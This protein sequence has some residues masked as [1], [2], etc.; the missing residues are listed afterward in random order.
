MK[1]NHVIQLNVRSKLTLIQNQ[2]FQ[3][4]IIRSDFAIV[5]LLLKFGIYPRRNERN[6]QGLTG[7]QQCVLDGNGRLAILLLEAGADIEAKTSNG[8]TCLHIAAALG[9]LDIVTTLVNHCSDMIALTKNEELPIDLAATREIK[10]KLAKEMSRIGYSELAQWY[11]RKLAAREGVFYVLS[12]DTLLDLACDD[13]KSYAT[14]YQYFVRPD[15]VEQNDVY[16]QPGNQQSMTSYWQVH[17]EEDGVFDGSKKDVWFEYPNNENNTYLSCSSGYLSE[18]VFDKSLGEYKKVRNS[19]SVSSAGSPQRRLPET[20]CELRNAKSMLS[21]TEDKKVEDFQTRCS[22]LKRSTSNRRRDSMQS[23]QRKPSKIELHIDYAHTADDEQEEDEGE[24]NGGL[25]QASEIQNENTIICNT[26]ENENVFENHKEKEQPK[27]R[28]VEQVQNKSNVIEHVQ[29]NR[30]V[31]EHVQSNRQVVEHGKNSEQY[32]T[33]LNSQISGTTTDLNS[34]GTTT[35][36]SGVTTDLNL[37]SRNRNVRFS[38]I[39]NANEF[40]NC[41]NCKK[42]GYAFS[43][44]IRSPNRKVIHIGEPV[45]V[46]RDMQP[47]YQIKKTY[48][49][50]HAADYANPHYFPATTDKL[51]T[52]YGQEYP[53]MG[54]HATCCG[55]EYKPR[56]KKKKLFSGIKSMFKDSIKVHRTNSDQT[57]MI[58]DAGILFAVSLRDRGKSKTIKERQLV[59]KSNSFSGRRSDDF[60]KEDVYPHDQ[61]VPP[62]FHFSDSYKDNGK[63]FYL[64]DDTFNSSTNTITQDTVNLPN[65]LPYQNELH[66]SQ[67]NSRGYC[68]RVNN[69]YNTG[70]DSAE[71]HD[72]KENEVFYDDFYPHQV[73][74]NHC[75]IETQCVLSDAR[76]NTVM[77][78][79]DVCDKQGEDCDFSATHTNKV[80]N[81]STDVL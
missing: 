33:Q 23:I 55:Q 79:M 64:F 51:S 18:V 41:P 74:D 2:I 45:Y 9:D 15:S 26:S 17:D 49:I 8:W 25:I 73:A 6:I 72:K 47:A 4:A 42:M 62:P 77:S 65:E 35:D 34:K 68:E 46:S 5:K 13:N 78:H 60:L 30:H 67:N 37:D 61:V 53:T 32:Y 10:I 16:L 39:D 48:G 70:Y 14:G 58:D 57:P 1:W 52:Y 63:T 21:I 19:S 80:E 38:K 81:G 3:E 40:C 22:T 31:I 11:M 28:I 43:P 75:D 44:D 56:K 59:R 27:S 54:K 20:N 36:I 24:E 76:I 50:V 12:T 29:S 69:L 71:V 7:L 66:D